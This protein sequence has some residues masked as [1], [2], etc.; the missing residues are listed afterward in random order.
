[1]NEDSG[2][3]GSMSFSF[4]WATIILRRNLTDPL[5]CHVQTISARSACFCQRTAW[6]DDA[7]PRPP[8]NY[9][10]PVFSYTGIF[11]EA[12]IL[13][14][15]EFQNRN[16]AESSRSLG[17]KAMPGFVSVAL[18]HR[19]RRGDVSTICWGLSQCH[20]GLENHNRDLNTFH[21]I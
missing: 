9:C 18:F 10:Y 5:S 13:I 16:E 15:P 14:V 7:K 21:Y 11:E 19:H 2:L 12:S 3:H 20:P 4:D 6:K 1:M 17:I 8:R